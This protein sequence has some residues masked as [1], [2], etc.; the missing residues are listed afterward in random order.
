MAPAATSSDVIIVTW[1]Q[2]RTPRCRASAVQID[3]WSRSCY[4]SRGLLQ[5]HLVPSCR[6]PLSFSSVC[7]QRRRAS[8]GQKSDNATA[9]HQLFETIY[10]GCSCVNEWT[11]QSSDGISTPS[12]ST[13]C[14]SRWFNH[15]ENQ[16][17]PWSLS[18]AGLWAWISLST[19]LKTTSL[20]VGQ[21]TSQ[22]K[23]DIMFY[24][25]LCWAAVMILSLFD[26]VIGKWLFWMTQN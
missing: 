8:G 25:A 5:Q 4:Q 20:T 23:T 3:A 15:T 11:T 18:A 1:W 16:N 6:G 7:A 21:F 24:Y 26:C 9:S 14:W 13:I 2:A 12:T 22:L 10:T 19:E 17:G